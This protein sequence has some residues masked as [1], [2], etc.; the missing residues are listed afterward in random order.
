MDT[1]IPETTTAPEGF[2]AFFQQHYSRILKFFKIRV[3][4]SGDA[5][6]L[7]QDVFLAAANA[8]QKPGTKPTL[9]WLLTIAGNRLKNYYRDQSAQKRD[10]QRETPFEEKFHEHSEVTQKHPESELNLKAELRKLDQVVQ[11]LPEPKRSCF[12]MHFIWG[13]TSSEISKLLRLNRDT[14]KSHIHRARVQVIEFLK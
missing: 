5:E 6:D 11:T 13:Y 4:D 7:T 1:L 14:V 8:F 9:A 3:N 12:E 10:R 2:Q